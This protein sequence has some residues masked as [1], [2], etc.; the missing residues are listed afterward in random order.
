[1]P[2]DPRIG[3]A[4]ARAATWLTPPAESIEDRAA[5]ADAAAAAAHEALRLALRAGLVSRPGDPLARRLRV[6]RSVLSDEAEAI[7]AL[8]HDQSGVDDQ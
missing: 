5:A 1:M 2:L 7:A 4:A 6:L 8:A 3:A